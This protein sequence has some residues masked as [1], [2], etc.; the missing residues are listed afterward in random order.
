MSFITGDQFAKNDWHR[1][2][3]TI[4]SN[5]LAKRRQSQGGHFSVL[6]GEWQADDGYGQQN[7]Q[8]QMSQ[9]YPDAANEKPDDVENCAHKTTAGRS[10]DD[11]AAKGDQDEHPQLEALKTKWNADDGDTQGKAADHVFDGNEKTA[12]NNP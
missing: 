5:I 4:L 9:A 1:Q 7:S 2:P 10:V 11:F 8:Q 6:F 3:E 12:Q